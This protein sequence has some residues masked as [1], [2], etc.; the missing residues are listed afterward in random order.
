MWSLLGSGVI[1]AAA[2]LLTINKDADRADD[3]SRRLNEESEA[4]YQALPMTSMSETNSARQT[5][6]KVE[7]PSVAVEEGMVDSGSF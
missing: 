7:S 2:A 1:I 3:E 6:S 5:V 4:I